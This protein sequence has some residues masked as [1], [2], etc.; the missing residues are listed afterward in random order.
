MDQQNEDQDL[1]E[2]QAQLEAKQAA[3]SKKEERQALLDKIAIENLRDEHGTLGVVALPYVEGYPTRVAFKSPG[4]LYANYEGQI[5][6]QIAKGRGA[7]SVLDTKKELAVLCWV[8]PVEKS[9]RE[10]V[11]ERFPGVV[12]SGATIVDRLAEGVAV[13]EGK[14]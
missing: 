8:Y 3:R 10:R 1:A 4:K 6:R 7:G 13:E 2:L 14:D 9:E 5:K 12:T 11:L